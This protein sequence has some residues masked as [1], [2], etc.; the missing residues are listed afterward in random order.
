MARIQPDLEPHQ[1]CRPNVDNSP[2]RGQG[3]SSY[4]TEPWRGTPGGW[5]NRHLHLDYLNGSNLP[6]T[7][8]VLDNLHRRSTERQVQGVIH[9]QHCVLQRIVVFQTSDAK[10][11]QLLL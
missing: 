1:Y 7:H 11:R 4:P 6:A 5:G 10:F 3:T 8:V 9:A 2:Y